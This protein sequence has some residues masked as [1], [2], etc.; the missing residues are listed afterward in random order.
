M[1]AFANE[2]EGTMRRALAFLAAALVAAAPAWAQGGVGIKGGLSYGNVTNRGLLPGNLDTRTGFAAGLFIGSRENLLG[3]GIEGLYAQRGVVSDNGPDS[4]E[5]DYIDVPGYLR[6]MIPAP[7]LGPYVY[8]GP[9]VSF[10]LACRSGG[11]DCPDT[12]RPKTTY[13]AVLG[14][15]VRIGGMQAFSLEGRYIY[16]LTDLKLETVTSSESYK[17]RSFLLLLGIRF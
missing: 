17:T 10:E 16:G 13:A 9:Q 4:R 5:L 6:V 2:T 3:W 8:A 11:A 14:G 1:D 12:D 15:G 7:A